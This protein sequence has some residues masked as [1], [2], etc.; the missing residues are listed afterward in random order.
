MIPVLVI[1]IRLKLSPF[2]N[3]LCANTVRLGITGDYACLQNTAG[4]S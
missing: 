4:S 3:I 2:H 1:E